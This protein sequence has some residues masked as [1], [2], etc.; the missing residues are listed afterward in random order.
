MELIRQNREKWG[1]ELGAIDP[2]LGS[3]HREVG[4]AQRFKEVKEQDIFYFG[5]EH[6][7]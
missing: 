4:F 1:Q 2:R 7:R 5:E 3:P 6:C